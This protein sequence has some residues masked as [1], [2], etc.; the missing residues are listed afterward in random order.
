MTITNRLHKT[1]FVIMLFFS[2]IYLGC[3]KGSSAVERPNPTDPEKPS[4]TLVNGNNVYGYVLDETK[5]P[6][7]NVSISDGF[8]VVKTDE[9]GIYQFKKNEKSKF[10]YYSTPSAYEIHVESPNRQVAL[11]YKA[12][13]QNS[14]EQVDFT[15]TRRKNK[16][17]NYMLFGIGDP[18]V[19]ND[20]DVERF[21]KETLQDMQA[22]LAKKQGEV[23]GLSLGDVV[24]DKPGL[25]NTMKTKLGSTKMKVFTTIG[26]HDKTST[27]QAQHK[28]SEVFENTYGPTNYSFEIGQ[29]HYIC[30]DNV[31]FE[32][33]SSYGL[34]INQNQINWIKQDLAQVSK[35]KMLIIYYHMPLRGTNFATRDQ[36]F[37][38]I[39][40]YKEVHLFS[41]HTHYAENYIHSVSSKQIYEHVHAATC[42]AWWKSTINGDG[43]PN[44]YMIYQIEGATIKNWVYKPTNRSIDFQLRLHWGDM[45]F[46]GQYGYFTYGQAGN[47]LVANVWNADPE[48]KVEIYM[49]N[50]K[51]GDMVH[52]SANPLNQDAWSKGFHLG[53]LNR[54]PSN[55]S[56]STKHL[57]TFKIDNPNSSV[58]VIATDRFGKTYEQTEITSDFSTAQSY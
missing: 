19:A 39:K 53:V 40:D 4:V 9:K 57:Y 49:D 7:A 10:V 24:A 27:A 34:G 17:D 41:G 16:V 1:A 35:E 37:E 29:V 12:L 47:T 31:V 3:S 56:T 54:N 21:S 13:A 25:L 43:T 46:G 23:Y 22:E 48:W 58:K 55:Y 20:S 8:T 36:F 18:Q 6:I 32:D 11:F 44:G 50:K 51:I 5:K 28:T 42:G 30:L 14:P 2:F 33:N 15:L 52:Q 26:N 38:L 45:S